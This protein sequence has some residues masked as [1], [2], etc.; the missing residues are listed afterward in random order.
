MFARRCVQGVLILCLSMI[1]VGCATSGLN[2][3]QVTPATSTQ[4]PVPAGGWVQFTATGTYHQGS[5]PATTQDLTDKVSWTSS[6]TDV[7]TIGATGFA[8]GVA[9]G[10]TT[11]TASMNGFPGFVSGSQVLSISSQPSCSSETSCVPTL[12]VYKLGNDAASGKVTG[13]VINGGPTVIDCGSGSECLGHFP[14]GSQVVLTATPGQNSTFGG[15]SSN[16]LPYPNNGPSPGSQ[17]MITMTMNEAV[18]AIFNPT[19]P[20]LL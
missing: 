3:I 17:C 11:I 5:H 12:T 19:Q 14:L 15:W 18:G 13:A 10:T 16:C 1:L 6:S 4:A 7:A 20:G 9:P 8:I 2:S